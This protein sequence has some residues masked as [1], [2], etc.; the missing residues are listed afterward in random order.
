VPVRRYHSSPASVP[1]TRVHTLAPRDFIPSVVICCQ[2]GTV[3]EEPDPRGWV[4]TTRDTYGVCPACL[5]ATFAA[6][7]E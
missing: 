3:A 5:D 6:L 4:M 1:D 7:G 2:C